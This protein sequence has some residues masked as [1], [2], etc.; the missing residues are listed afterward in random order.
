MV[1]DPFFFSRL[2]E[3]ARGRLEIGNHDRRLWPTDTAA[4]CAT[5]RSSRSV[6][7]ASI[8]EL[9]SKMAKLERTLE[10]SRLSLEHHCR[11]R[12]RMRSR[13]PRHGRRD[14]GTEFWFGQVSKNESGEPEWLE[15]GTRRRPK[16]DSRRHGSWYH[17][18]ADSHSGGRSGGGDA[19]KYAEEHEHGMPLV[20][21]L[22]S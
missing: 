7:K 10:R 5:S 4:A 18:I 8:S 21:D 11:R 1:P 17:Y 9:I 2:R 22:E 14:D 20:G 3:S 12:W 6:S 16:R 19:A 13:S 15:D